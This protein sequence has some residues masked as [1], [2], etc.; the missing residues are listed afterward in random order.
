VLRNAFGAQLNEVEE[1]LNSVSL[2]EFRNRNPRYDRINVDEIRDQPYREQ[3]DYHKNK[4]T[5]DFELKDRSLL[6]FIW[7]EFID[8]I[9]KQKTTNLKYTYLVTPFDAE[10]AFAE[11]KQEFDEFGFSDEELRVHW[12]EEQTT[13]TRSTVTP[14]RYDYQ[15]QYYAPGVEPASHFHF[16]EDNEIRICTKKILQPLSFALFI[17]RQCYPIQWK[18]CLTLGK[19]TSWS[20]LIREALDDVTHI[21]MA[22]HDQ[23]ELILH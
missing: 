18:S 19:M 5:Y 1:F 20:R 17:C 9:K 7:S 22:G 21:D 13:I 16:G 6:Q 4:S 15:P 8:P 2:L 11:Y 12:E 23:H 14:V 3:F 10:K